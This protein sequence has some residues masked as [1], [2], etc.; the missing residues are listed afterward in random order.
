[1]YLGFCLVDV[2]LQKS[3]CYT[4]IYKSGAI[5][6]TFVSQGLR[7]NLTKHRN[8]HILPFYRKAQM[9]SRRLC[10]VNSS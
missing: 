6:L 10:T 3:N 9:M 8:N 7:A 5:T 2:K 4:T 1:M